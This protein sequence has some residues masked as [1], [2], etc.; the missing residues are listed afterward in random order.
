[1][2]QEY[3]ARQRADEWRR[4]SAEHQLLVKHRPEKHVA[5]PRWRS[6]WN[7]NRPVERPPIQA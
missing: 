4:A 5:R 3:V 2:L 6:R 1:M 7:W